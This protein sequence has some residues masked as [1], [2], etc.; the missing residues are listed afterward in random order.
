MMHKCGM[1]FSSGSWATVLTGPHCF[2]IF[3]ALGLG[4]KSKPQTKQPKE[5]LLKL[6]LKMQISG[7]KLYTLC[8]VLNG[9]TLTQRMYIFHIGDI[10]AVF[11]V[12]T[13]VLGPSGRSPEG[14]RRETDPWLSLQLTGLLLFNNQS[15][16][17]PCC[18]W[19]S[20]VPLTLSCVDSAHFNHK[21]MSFRG[22][23]PVIFHILCDILL[24]TCI[25]EWANGFLSLWPLFLDMISR[26]IQS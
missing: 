20:M 13:L 17:E 4:R 22:T 18:E 1:G 8:V 7:G 3:W 25:H 14:G 11:H 12:F 6:W 26:F 24:F 15:P 21:I 16:T 2:Q 23:R 10:L 19:H 5:N 9:S